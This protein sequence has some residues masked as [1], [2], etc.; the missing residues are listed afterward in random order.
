MFQDLE[1]KYPA[2]KYGDTRPLIERVFSS[3]PEPGLP[4][5][6]RKEAPAAYD[7]LRTKAQAGGL[8]GETQTERNRRLAG[9]KE[10]EPPRLLDTDEQTARTQ[11][12]EPEIDR[13]LANQKAGSPDNLVQM[14]KSEPLKDYYV[15]LAAWSYGKLSRRPVKPQPRTKEV[16]ETFELAPELCAKFNVAPKTHVSLDQ[17]ADLSVKYHAEKKAEAERIA[18]LTPQPEHE[19]PA[20]L[21]TPTKVRSA[22]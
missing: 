14:A 1:A 11:F 12:S 13:I 20:L 4:M 21:N 15:R 18:A 2:K 6:L 8:V 9:V 3:N 7:A 22:A 16:S 17:F 5:K 19:E 10:P